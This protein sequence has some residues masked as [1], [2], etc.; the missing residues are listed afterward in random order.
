MQN[1]LSTIRDAA[2]TLRAR[3]W[4]RVAVSVVL[5]GLV[6][7]WWVVGPRLSA[8]TSRVM[9]WRAQEHRLDDEG[10]LEAR[11][12]QLRGEESWLQTRLDSLYV[13]VPREDRISVVLDSLQTNAV[14]SD[15][16]MVAIRPGRVATSATYET[17]PLRLQVRGSFHEIGRLVDRVERMAYLVVVNHLSLTRTGEPSRR[18][19][20][21]VLTAHLRLG[22]V[23][24]RPDSL[25]TTAHREAAAPPAGSV[26][27]A[28]VLPKMT[29]G[30]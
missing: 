21:P 25:Q 3:P 13:R 9:E 18:R 20:R 8:T 23:T 27:D 30:S 15:V 11:L 1:V 22:V 19:D 12:T 4:L 29:E 10:A 28:S 2:H 7:L 26:P 6:L 16:T 24:L 5:A 14:R 17:L